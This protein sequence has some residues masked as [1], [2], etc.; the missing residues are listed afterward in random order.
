MNSTNTHAHTSTG[1]GWTVREYPTR[2]EVGYALTTGGVLKAAWLDAYARVPREAFLPDTIWP[3]D[4]AA[5]KAIHVSRSEDAEAWRGY[6]HADVPIVTQWDDGHHAGREPGNVSTS[7]ASM[8]SVVFRMLDALRVDDYCRVLEIGT[9][10]GWNAALLA[11]K[12]GEENVVTVEVDE[13]V[14]SRARDALAHYFGMPVDVLHGDGRAGAPGR[15]VFDRVVATCGVRSIPY[16]WITQ[17]RPGGVIVAPWGTAFT[18]ADALVRL[19]VGPEGESASGR[20]L[21]PVEFMKLRAHRTA[22]LDHEAYAHQLPAV[23]HALV[24][25]DAVRA[26]ADADRFDALPFALG[27]RVPHCS[28][29]AA[30]ARG[31]T[32]PHWLYSRRDRSWACALLTDGE[33]AARVWQHGGRH[34][35]DEARAAFE[36]WVAQG[37]PGWERFGLT[38]NGEGERVWLDEEGRGL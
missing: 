30:P 2:E 36:W 19:R 23:P 7:S 20:F 37:R 5:G 32:R 17:T 6:A 9:G 8:P 11:H 1:G 16:A 18:N 29:V 26:L 24:S 13:G 21:G 22:P 25:A 28:Y 35:W 10:T 14:A 31:D 4:M 12:V 38:V 15:G 34:L 3:F 33:D 27:L